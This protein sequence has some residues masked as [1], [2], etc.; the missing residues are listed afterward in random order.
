MNVFV[1]GDR[2]Q[3]FLNRNVIELGSHKKVRVQYSAMRPAE[4][5]EK[6]VLVYGG[7]TLVAGMVDQPAIFS[8]QVA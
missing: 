3:K 4:I 2:R 8:A 6:E 7:Q 5:L 1:T